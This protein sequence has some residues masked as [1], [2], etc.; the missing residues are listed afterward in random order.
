MARPRVPCKLATVAHRCRHPI[1][2]NR[3][4]GKSM[5][6][7]PV[8][9]RLSFVRLAAATALGLLFG[10]MILVAPLAKAGSPQQYLA[11]GDSIAFG[12][13]PLLNPVNADN[14]IGYPTPAAAGLKKTLTNASCPGETSSHFVSLAGTDNG[15]GFWRTFYPLHAEY[16]TSQLAFADAFL[17]ANP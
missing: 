2:H 16:A 6:R 14:F 10:V 11:L 13:S 15:C 12:F 7:I 1:E 9:T 17:Q 5:K 4:E 3:C 8:H